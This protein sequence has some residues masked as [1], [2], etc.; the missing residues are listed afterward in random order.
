MTTWSKDQSNILNKIDK[1]T[2]KVR[3]VI[4]YNFN[5]YKIIMLS[6]HE[7][8]ID[9]LD[10][11]SIYK[12]IPLLIKVFLYMK[13]TPLEGSQQC[14][15]SR[16]SETHKTQKNQVHSGVGPGTQSAPLTEG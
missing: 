11:G 12:S 13:L 4:I 15:S 3:Q 14:L 9:V 10:P 2:F 7:Q 8:L 5:Q 16:G 6:Q 1:Y